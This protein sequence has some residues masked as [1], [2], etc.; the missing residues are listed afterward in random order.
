MPTIIETVAI[1]SAFIAIDYA[2][3]PANTMDVNGSR[4]SIS[5]NLSP[6]NY[7][8]FSTAFLVF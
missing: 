3:N 7:N 2:A 4:N 1:A 6:I 5:N 8:S